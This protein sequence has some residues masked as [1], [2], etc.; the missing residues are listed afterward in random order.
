MQVVNDLPSAKQLALPDLVAKQVVYYL[1]EPF[2]DIREAEAF[3]KEC[4]ST[5]VIFNRQSNQTIPDDFLSDVTTHFI[6]EAINN[7]EIQHELADNYQ[8]MLTITSDDGSGLYVVKPRE[9]EL[10]FK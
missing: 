7:P 2:G 9:L 1:V 8:M 3:Y 6:K 10:N 5:L 4:S